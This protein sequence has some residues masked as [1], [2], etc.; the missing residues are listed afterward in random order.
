[1]KI[2]LGIDP[3][4]SNTGYGIIQSD[5]TKY[6]HVSHG[7]IRTD[8]KDNHGF[9]LK[10][11]YDILD[12]LIKKYK[13]DE[14]GIETLYFAKN[15]KTAMPVSEAR[16]VIILCLEKN[17]INFAEYTPL[18]VKQTLIGS[19][20]ALKSQVKEMVKIVFGL[21]EQVKADHAADALAIAFCHSSYCK[22][23]AI[24]L[25]GKQ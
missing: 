16:G 13:P 11:I 12:K 6:K 3:G 25:S 9:R 14:A 10:K 2:I 23:K 15:V 21:E 19:G 8:S 24:Y 22:T 17:N 20:R 18:V 4:L 7:V 5:G 1:M